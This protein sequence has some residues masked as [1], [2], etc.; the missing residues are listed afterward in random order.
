MCGC[1]YIQLV[2]QL[3]HNI[4]VYASTNYWQWSMFIILFS[5]SAKLPVDKQMKK[6]GTVVVKMVNRMIPMVFLSHLCMVEL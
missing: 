1:L 2:I 6:T 3:E 5:S 4:E